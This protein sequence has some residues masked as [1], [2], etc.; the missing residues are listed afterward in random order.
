MRT[1]TVNLSIPSRMQKLIADLE[2]ELALAAMVDE[3]QSP[4]WDVSSLLGSPD[5]DPRKEH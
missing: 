2:R 4:E 5:D 1:S 3:C